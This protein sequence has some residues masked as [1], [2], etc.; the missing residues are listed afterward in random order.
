MD[1]RWFIEPPAL[2]AAHP[3]LGTPNPTVVDPPIRAV[4][5]EVTNLPL[6]PVALNYYHI[7]IEFDIACHK[8]SP[9]NC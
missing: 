8:V 4:E 9:F 5:H 1:K 6:Y 3:A 2:L 7:T